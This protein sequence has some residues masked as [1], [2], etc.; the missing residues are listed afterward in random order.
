[1]KKMN[2]RET[3]KARKLFEQFTKDN[4]AYEG[5]ISVATVTFRRKLMIPILELIKELEEKA[6]E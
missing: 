6:D 5:Q 3:V 1:M 4:T 2:I